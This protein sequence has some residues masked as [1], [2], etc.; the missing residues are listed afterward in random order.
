MNRNTFKV[1]LIYPNMYLM[2]MLPPAIAILS[3]LLKKEGYDVE[4]FDTT[5]HITDESF[6]SDKEKEKH[7]QVRPFNLEGTGIDTKT[8]NVIDDLIEKVE[9]FQPNLIAMSAVEDTFPLGIRLLKAIRHFQ[10]PTILGGVFS[11]FAPEKAIAYDEIDIVCVGEGEDALL[12]LCKRLKKGQKYDDIPNLWVK[13]KSGSVKRNPMGARVDID[14]LPMP[15]FTLFEEARLYR[16][17]AGEVYRMIPFETHRGCPYACAFC[18]SPT[19]NALYKENINTNYFRRRSMDSVRKEIDWLINQWNPEYMYFTADTFLA[20]SDKEFDEFIETYSDYKLPFWC[21]TRAETVTDYRMKKLKSVGLHRMSIGLEHGNEQF[22]RDVVIRNYSNS[23][24]QEAFAI[25]AK[26]EIP[27]SVNN[28]VGFPLETRELAFDTINLNRKIIE[29]IDT[30]NCYAFAPFHG[31]PMRDLA[32][33]KGFLDKNTIG[34]C[35]TK[36]SQLNMPNFPQEQIYGIMR[37]FNLY[38]RFEKSRWKEI[39]IAEH[40]TIEGNMVFEKLRDEFLAEYYTGESV[41]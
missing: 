41:S 29:G 32:V 22:R 34:T 8:T 15:D 31:T 9:T 16:P 1:L 5:Y 17:M 38:T 2:N 19:Q 20:W 40:E 12:T 30:A 21:Q 37:T 35:L 14:N 24:I 39:E 27:V 7:L 18:N 11:T 10:I 25:T 4:L 23:V 6:N 26:Y 3:S 28:I 36:G 13:E 33:E